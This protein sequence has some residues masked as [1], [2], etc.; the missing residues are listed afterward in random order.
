[1]VT[2]EDPLQPPRGGHRRTHLLSSSDP[3]M[4]S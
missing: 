3:V 4:V 2:G 1:V